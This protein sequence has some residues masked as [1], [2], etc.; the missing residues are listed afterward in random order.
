MTQG[1]SYPL[2]ADS[3]IPGIESWMESVRTTLGSIDATA[4]DL[5]AITSIFI[6]ME[7]NGD[8]K[9]TINTNQNAKSVKVKALTTGFPTS[10]QIAA[11]SPYT[12]GGD[13][14]VTTNTLATLS[15]GQRVYVGAIAYDYISR[16]SLAFYAESVPVGVFGSPTWQ[17]TTSETP[18]I[19][20]LTLTIN[21]PNSIVTKVEFR[22]KQGNGAWSAYAE[23]AAAPYV[24][25]VTLVE[26]EISRIGFRITYTD[27]TGSSAMV[28]DEV[29]F[30]SDPTAIVNVP[31][32]V[33]EGLN[34][35]V[36]YFGNVYTSSIWRKDRG[37]GFGTGVQV[38]SGRTGSELIALT[39]SRQDFD[40]YGKNSDTVE[41]PVVEFSV[42]P[43]QQFGNLGSR[44]LDNITGGVLQVGLL[45]DST[46]N[47]G[48]RV[49]ADEPSPT[50]EGWVRYIDLGATGSLPFIYHPNFQLLADGTVVFKNNTQNMLFTDAKAEHSSSTFYDYTGFEEASNGIAISTL[51]L[52]VGDTISFGGEAKSTAGT[53]GVFFSVVFWD[54]G[55]SVISTHNTT[56]VN[57]S[58]YTATSLGNVTVP[59]GTV[60]MS[61]RGDY[62][63]ST[64]TH[65][66][67]KAILNFGPVLSYFVEPA[68]TAITPQGIT[69]SMIAADAITAT[70]LA[71]NSVT[72]DAIAANSIDAGDINAGAI[73]A[74]NLFATGVI[75]AD[76]I[77]ANQIVA[78]KLA[79]GSINA[80]NLF[81]TGVVTSTAILAG[82]IQGTDIDADTITGNN[83]AA[84]SITAGKIAAGAINA[85]NLFVSGV[86]DATAIA[87][88][89]IVAGKIAAGAIDASN[90][91]VAGVVNAAAIGAAQIT[92]GKIAAGA[93]NA[94]N[95]FVSGVVDATAIATDAIVAGKIAAGA[96]DASNIFVAGVVDS[97]AI[98]ANTIVAGDIASNTITGNE[99]FGTTLSGIFVDAGEITAGQIHN[100]ADTYGILISG[101]LPGTWTRY[102]NFIDTSKA[103]LK[104]E[105]LSLN[106]DGS[107]DFQGDLTWSDLGVTRSLT[108]FRSDAL[109]WSLIF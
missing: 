37:A 105:K 12:L 84:G 83:M 85:S 38:V 78:G 66:W 74:S 65:Y 36:E 82:T 8:V 42:P 81:A 94:S 29:E 104:H 10:A 99:I 53:D 77:G 59:G 95:L 30:R 43:Q 72:A 4:L 16:P 93:I 28:E 48:L 71:T 50:S 22:Q 61:F 39:G 52:E 26:D 76:A 54:S 35:R 98:A 51:G 86:V 89:A 60:S 27:P 102:L 20:T 80:S 25:Q 106:W 15:P 34:A 64:E 7:N 11:E 9:A 32:V 63:G 91:F 5:P 55:P 79:V 41:G 49:D 100:V 33:V 46:G 70:Q 21:D 109:A 103:F 44:I 1:L 62:S 69:T 40:C 3:V 18:T 88:D 87:A 17:V 101:T 92:A 24:A 31:N 47:V 57:S 73:N 107:A 67:R 45:E 97:T 90:I 68:I 58:T 2:G 19:G 23:D 108:D 56:T 96:I 6:F 14:K 75:Q 13:T